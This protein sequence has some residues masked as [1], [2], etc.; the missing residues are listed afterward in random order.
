MFPTEG[1]PPRPTCTLNLRL[2]AVPR[3]A[4]LT[5]AS[6]APICAGRG[7]SRRGT[8]VQR[9]SGRQAAKSGRR[10]RGKP[11]GQAGAGGACR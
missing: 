5:A 9:L 2:V 8:R 10:G 1:R 4:A 7:A 11:T 6:A 3:L